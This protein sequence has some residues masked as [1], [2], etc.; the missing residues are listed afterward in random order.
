M[1]VNMTSKEAQQTIHMFEDSKKGRQENL[2]TL[3]NYLF[4]HQTPLQSHTWHAKVERSK[5]RHHTCP[6]P[7]STENC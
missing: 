4:I 2:S 5:S 3:R 6:E 7:K 1:A